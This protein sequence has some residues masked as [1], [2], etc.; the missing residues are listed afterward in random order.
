MHRVTS[1]FYDTV[2]GEAVYLWRDR[3]GRFWHATGAWSLFRIRKY[4]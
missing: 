3:M 4:Y 1:V 2:G